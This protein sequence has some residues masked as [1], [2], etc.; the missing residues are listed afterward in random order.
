MSDDHGTADQPDAAERAADQSTAEQEIRALHEAWFAASRAKDLDASMAPMSDDIVSYEHS[1]PLQHD[2]AGMREECR[3]GFELQPDDFEWTVPDLRVIVRDD[4]AVTWGL[5]RM[6]GR[7]AD[8]TE[9]VTWSRGTRIFRR[10]DGAW[11][12]IHQHV[13][14][15][16]DDE[17]GAAATGLVP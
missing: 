10:V 12:M 3:R 11:K 8:G 17:T 14:F 4:I 5:N 6:A 9:R 13:S 1:A 16:V 7:D 2:V 15:P